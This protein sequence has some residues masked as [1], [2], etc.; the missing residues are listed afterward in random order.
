[1]KERL[2]LALCAVFGCPMV[3]TEC[4]GYVTCARCKRQ[5]GDA[6]GGSC[7]DMADF[8]LVG[9]AC[10]GCLKNWGTLFWHEKLMVGGKAKALER[11]PDLQEVLEQIRAE[12]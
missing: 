10:D 1:M 9:H 7:P 3:V 2:K 12:R 6:L 4:W 8:V 5:I 11:T